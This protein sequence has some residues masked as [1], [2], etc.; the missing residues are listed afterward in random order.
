MQSLKLL[1]RDELIVAFGELVVRNNELATHTNQQA[2]IIGQLQQENLLLRQQQAQQTT[3]VKQLQDQLDA[4]NRRL[5]RNSKN[6]SMPPS[7]DDAIPGRT[8]PENSDTENANKQAPGKKKRGKQPGAT[9]TNLKPV[10]K[11]DNQTSVYA[12]HCVCGETL[13]PDADPTVGT[14]SYQQID[15]PH[16]QATFTQ[17]NL[18]SLKCR[19]GHVNEAPLPAGVTPAPIAY[20][21]NIQAFCVYLMVAHALPVERTAILIGQICSQRPSDGFVHGLLR[22]FGTSLDEFERRIKQLIHNSHVAHFDE[23]TL[24]CGKKGKKKPYVWS[25]STNNYTVY[26]LGGR[27]ITDLETFG[28]VKYKG[29]AVHDRYSLYDTAMPKVSGHQLCCAHL[30]RD[31]HDCA[32]VY[33]TAQWPTQVAESISSLIH[34]TNELRDT[35]IRVF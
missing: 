32:E 27:S 2:V 1:S 35:Q 15:I 29:I 3:L 16:I 13:D 26:H 7:T 14:K 25:G 34:A 22:R 10:D 4:L 5:S 12:S 30:L 28:F 11:P 18:H 19:C 8:S 33:P 24:R 23:T 21:P 17:Y 9:G 6:S 31:L 20:G